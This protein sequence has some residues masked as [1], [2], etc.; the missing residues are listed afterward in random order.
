VEHSSPPV[1]VHAVEPPRPTSPETI[2]PLTQL[3]PAATCPMNTY[4]YWVLA[5]GSK[6]HWLK[7][8]GLL[9][10]NW[11]GVQFAGDGVV[12]ATSF[13]GDGEIVGEEVATTS[14]VGEGRVV[15]V[16]GMEVT[17]DP[18]TRSFASEGV[19][20]EDVATTSRVGDG[21]VVKVVGR[22]DE[23]EATRSLAN[24]G[25]VL[26]EVATRSTEGDGR[27]VGRTDEV[28]ATRSFASEGVVLDEV[29]RTSA[30]GEGSVVNEGVGVVTA[31][32]MSFVGVGAGEITG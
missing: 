6:M 32:K 31:C 22:M 16:V 26:E 19:T 15:K 14:L 28:E 30:D 18:A 1:G 25:V 29:A 4:E 10:A 24:K 27:V 20:V 7:V 23:V 12:A 13:T 21:R 17:D 8:A 3:V 5:L 2:W 11:P 9:Q